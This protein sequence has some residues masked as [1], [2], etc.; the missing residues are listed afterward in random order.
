MDK[1]ELL[2]KEYQTIL[3]IGFSMA[4]SFFVYWALVQFVIP[5]PNGPVNN[6]EFFRYGFLV[7]AMIGPATIPVI[8]KAILR[9]SPD[10]PLEVS[11]RRLRVSAIV[12]FALCESSALVGLVSYLI[13]GVLMDFYILLIYSLIFFA[14]FF[15]K[16]S[17]WKE[18]VS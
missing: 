3:F 4:S 6:P 18:Y 9:K 14:I 13:A 7:I 10:D 8:K 16:H 1:Y 11:L 15:P 2:K 5:A 12:S 17:D